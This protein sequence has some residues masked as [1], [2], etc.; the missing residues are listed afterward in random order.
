MNERM[1]EFEGVKLP[2]Y[3][4]D[5]DIT[6]GWSDFTKPSPRDASW[7]IPLGLCSGAEIHIL[8]RV[9]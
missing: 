4:C 6:W 2:K 5:V 8:K 1:N 9:K 7:D 3:S